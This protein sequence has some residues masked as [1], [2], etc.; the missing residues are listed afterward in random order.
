MQYVYTPEHVC[1]KKFMIEVDDETRV[2][3]N[4]EFVGGC[5]GN[6]E[7]IGRLI[8]GMKMDD[9]IERFAD[10][11]I[12]RTSK[13]TSCPEQLGKALVEMKALLDKGETQSRPSFGLDSFSSLKH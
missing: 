12:C 9:V 6:L 7:G 2:I 8:R 1:S 3:R 13:V 5:P 10:M 11:P 4:F